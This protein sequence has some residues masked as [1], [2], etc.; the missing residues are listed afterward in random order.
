MNALEV[1]GRAGVL[2]SPK[3]RDTHLDRL[4]VVYVRQSDP[5]QVLNHRESRERQYALADH[6]VALGWPRERVLVIDDDQGQSGRTADRRGGFQ[7]LLA[8]VTMEHVGLILGIEMSRIARNNRDWHN[9][10]EMCAVFG[11]ILADEDGVYDPQDTNDRLLLGL[12]GTISE[13]EL[14]T[15]RNRLERG[16]L[17]KAH[18][19]ELFHRVPT[20]YVKLSTERVEFDP[21][22]QVREVIRLIFDKYDEIGTAWGV[23]HY[24]VRNNIKLGFRPFHGANRGN[25]EW[26]RPVLL[27]VFQILR[28]PIYAGAYAYGRRPHKRV[29][30]AAGDR[31]SAGNWVPMEQWKVLKRD[32]LPAYITWERYLTNQQSLHQHRSG[33]GSKG[34]PR[35]GCALLAG[36]VVCGNCG[37]CLQPSY[38]THARAYYSCVRHLHEGTEQAC[39]G[40]KAATVDDLVT[41]QILRALEPAALELSCRALEDVQRDRARLD[42]HWKQRLER[43]RYEAVDAERRYRAVDPDNRLVARSLEQRWEETLRAERQVRDD[44]GRFL[45]EQPPQLSHEERA[46]IAALSSDLPTLWHAAGTTDQDRKEIIRHLVEKVVVH[47]KNDSE[48]VDLAIH[49]Q[50]GFASRHEVVR[51][52][53]SY[54]Q[55]RDFDKLMDRIAALRGEGH[56]SAQIAECLNREGFSPPKRCGAFF[57][58][59]VRQLLKRRGLANEKTYTDQLG[60]NE[61]WLPKLAEEVPVSAGKLADWTR[62]GWIHSRKT[63]AQRLWV[64]WADKQELKRLRKLAALSHRGVVEYPPELTTP[65]EPGRG[66]QSSKNRRS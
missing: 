38:R 41:Q 55:L 47:V 3:I 51:P 14:V 24:L 61:W 40:L 57:P 49:W 54:E 33:P 25:L 34:S 19:G 15:M 26:R 29:R 53:K 1:T 2:R 12:K 11:S 6:A 36:L 10:L 27:T 30:T 18:R 63:P 32:C 43:A 42:K 13:F 56:T 65:K 52:V 50:G 21:D 44:Y 5:Q 35:D 23:F 7:R 8:E 28:H 39:F 20:G 45:R 66:P 4:A 59:L 58:E 60:P 17:N 37:R 16:R 46:R 9:L 62:R 22:E 48:Y 31:T 64:L